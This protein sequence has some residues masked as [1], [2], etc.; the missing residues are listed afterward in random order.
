MSS[1]AQMRIY[2]ICYRVSL[3]VIYT[4]I[5]IY[6]KFGIIRTRSKI[7]REKNSFSKNNFSISF[8]QSLD[9]AILHCT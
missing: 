6:L 3:I 7:C 5:Q 4:T 9:V 8:K 1:N 2:Q